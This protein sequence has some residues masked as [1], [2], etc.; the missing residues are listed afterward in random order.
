MRVFLD[1]ERPCPAGWTL[2]R[3]PDEAIELLK[4][5]AVTEISLDHDLGDDERGTGYDVVL[6]IE[7]QVML[8]GFK[9]PRMSVHSANSS[10]RQKMMAGIRA[11]ESRWAR[12]ETHPLGWG[13]M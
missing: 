9:P 8:H 13:G 2:V 6:W 11:I 5:G 12:I 7:E 10:A 3:W 1:D 4:T